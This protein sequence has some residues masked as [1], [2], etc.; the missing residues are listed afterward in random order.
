MQTHEHGVPQLFEQL[1]LATDEESIADFI[2]Q[3][4]VIEGV[5]LHK[6]AFWTPSQAQF[7]R[8]SFHED[9]DW[10]MAIDQLNTALRKH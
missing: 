4:H 1:G 3:H 6:A 7:L 8:E 5:A 9:S 10:V 2:E